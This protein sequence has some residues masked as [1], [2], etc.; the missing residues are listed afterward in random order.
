MFCDIEEKQILTSLVWMLGN[1]GSFPGADV[2]EE[3]LRVIR[4]ACKDINGCHKC[5]GV[6]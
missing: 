6:L 2:V 4:V 1:V 5:E 3:D